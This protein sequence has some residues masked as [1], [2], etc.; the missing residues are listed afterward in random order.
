MDAPVIL[1]LD[2]GGTKIAAAVCEISGTRLGTRTIDALADLGAAS[3]LRRG[4]DA[5]R[6]LLDEVAPGRSV[7]AVGACTFGIPR[8]DRID[9]APTIPG[10]GDLA[11]GSELRAAFA[12]AEIRLATD[13]K[14]AAYAEVQWGALVGC[15]PGIY[16]NLGTGLAVAIVANGSVV[17]GRNG[18]AGEIGYNLR[19][20][21]DV[22]A[23][24]AQRDSLEEAVSGRALMRDAKQ[25]APLL[26]T[27]AEVFAAAVDDPR[28]NRLLADFVD[29]L[30]YHLVNL[31]I[32]ID[33]A[34]IVVG[35]GMV[36]SW[37][38]LHGSLRHALDQAVPFPP[39]LVQA[40]FPF[41][42]PLMGAI[43]LSTAAA[44][45]VHP[46]GAHA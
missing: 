6:G 46:E 30:S 10:W 5:A 45:D 27:P 17:A 3:G 42:A 20:V 8:D 2:F 9:L 33:P 26:E 38:H 41:D 1:G 15:D 35:G 14:A 34:R 12:D 13:V 25:I 18:A 43:A 31:T 32:A 36:R 19:S 21:R 44:R 11:L 24:S 40:Q 4:I 37:D 39:E 16:L 22:G 7:V 28:V 29:E 23:P